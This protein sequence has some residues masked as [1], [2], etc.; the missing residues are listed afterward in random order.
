MTK[1]A[2]GWI[3]G[4]RG[5]VDWLVLRRLWLGSLPMAVMTLIWLHNSPESNG[6]AKLIIPTLAVALILTG[7]AMFAR[8]VFHRIGERLRTNFPERFKAYQPA[9][10]VFAGALL[11]F[12]VTLTSVGAGALGA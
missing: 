3:H 4:I 10:T 5:A 6:L 7:F 8:P 11:G 2:G 12:L 9:L 1:T